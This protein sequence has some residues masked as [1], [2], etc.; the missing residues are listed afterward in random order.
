MINEAG[1][2][3]G[4]VRGVLLPQGGVLHSVNN[5]NHS[6]SGMGSLRRSYHTGNCLGCPKQSNRAVLTI[7]LGSELTNG[8]CP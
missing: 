2:S 3:V 6:V 5:P 8:E 4:A 1:G 7:A